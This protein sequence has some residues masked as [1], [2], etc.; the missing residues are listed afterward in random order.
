MDISV[1]T[2]SGFLILS[3]RESHTLW[4]LQ[5]VTGGIYISNA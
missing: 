2:M 5:T 3:Q 1:L 4:D